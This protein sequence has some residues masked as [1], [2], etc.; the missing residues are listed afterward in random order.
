VDGGTVAQCTALLALDDAAV[1]LAGGQLRQALQAWEAAGVLPRE[2]SAGV[3]DSVL[4]RLATLTPRAVP[5]VL[6]GVQTTVCRLYQS[7]L[8]P[9]LDALQQQVRCEPPRTHVVVTKT[10]CVHRSWRGCGW[11]RAP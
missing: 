10:M 8:G 11:R 5:E 9:S 1:A 4:A 3:L 2:P 6:V 7:L